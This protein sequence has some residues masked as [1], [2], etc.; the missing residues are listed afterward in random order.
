MYY[1]VLQI[2]QK[3]ELRLLLFVLIER[4][5]P[6]GASVLPDAAISNALLRRSVSLTLCRT[7]LTLLAFLDLGSTRF[8]KRGHTHNQVSEPPK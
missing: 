3:S 8:L 5:C 2:D 4:S 7:L 6:T 1:S